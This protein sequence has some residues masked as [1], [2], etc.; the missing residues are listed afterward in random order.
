[1]TPSDANL[2]PSPSA[3]KP[4]RSEDAANLQLRQAIER[5]GPWHLQIQVTPQ[6][7]TRAWVEFS[8]G[9]PTSERVT[10]IDPRPA[11]EAIVGRIYPEGLSGRSFLDCACNC[12]AYSF[13]AKELGAGE[14]FGFDIREHWI[15]QAHFL[16]EH[17]TVG[18]KAGIRFEVGDLYDLR[19]KKLKPFDV[20]MF[21]G[22]FYHL[23]D[24]ITGLKIAADMTNELL[25]FNSASRSGLPDGLLAIG[26]ESSELLMSGVYGLNWL[27]TGP[28]V[29]TQIL[30]WAGFVETH[31]LTWQREAE[32]GFGRID[33]LASK[34]RGLLE[35]Y[36][37]VAT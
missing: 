14:C 31:V 36:R 17:R 28:G 9:S 22:I 3:E 19:Q 4:E 29:L 35:K 5:L 25:I 20:T 26:R 10:F 32:P 13:L 12:G 33:L 15:R 6:L 37:A 34:K 16:L 11:F 24:P 23:P 18:P 1:M 2:E 8:E 21:K 7:D 27:P 30:E